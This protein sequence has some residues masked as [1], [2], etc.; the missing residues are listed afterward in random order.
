MYLQKQLSRYDRLAVCVRGKE[1][2]LCE[3]FWWTLHLHRIILYSIQWSGS[4]LRCWQ[5]CSPSRRFTLPISPGLPTS[6]DRRVVC[7]QTTSTPWTPPTW[8]WHHSAVTG[9][10]IFLFNK[11]YNST[12]CMFLFIHAGSTSAGMGF[13]LWLFMIATGHMLA[14]L[15]RW[16]G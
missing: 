14:S 3:W 5:T 15:T 13:H 8:C 2:F 10:D 16:T 6:E 12:T 1:L 9:R 11:N 4:P 7:H